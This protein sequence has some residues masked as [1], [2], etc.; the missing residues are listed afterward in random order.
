[1]PILESR[2]MS[3]GCRLS[4]WKHG[5]ITVPRCLNTTIKFSQSENKTKQVYNMKSARVPQR[6]NSLHATRRTC[7]GGDGVRGACLGERQKL[8]EGLFLPIQR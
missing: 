5:T 7:V 3:D 6:E 2:R 1:M 4:N 8:W